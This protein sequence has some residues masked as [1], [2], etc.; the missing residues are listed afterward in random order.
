MPPVLRSVIAVIAGFLTL[1]F[2]VI[3]LTLIAVSTMHLKSGHPTPAYLVLNVVYSFFAAA[4]AGFVA[5]LIA[6]RKPLQH[7]ASLAA[8]MLAF[9]IFSYY[10]YAGT[11]PLWYQLMMMIVP[12]LCVLAGGAI[13][14]RREAADR[15]NIL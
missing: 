13:I 14:A 11:Q 10:K 5:A 9:G 3:V 6:G 15:L 1:N 2:I 7:A 12:P 8:I 4:A